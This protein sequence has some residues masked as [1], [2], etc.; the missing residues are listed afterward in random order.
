MVTDDV[1][2]LVTVAPDVP[3][4]TVKV[5]SVTLKVTVIDDEPASASLMLRPLFLRLSD[6]CSVFEYDAGVIVATG[7]SLT[8]VMLMV[9]VAVDTRLPP[10]PVL[11]LSLTDRVRVEVALGVSVLST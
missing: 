7:A 3:A 2:E 6:T 4:V 11:P 8:A 5:P 1:P 9:D 10:V